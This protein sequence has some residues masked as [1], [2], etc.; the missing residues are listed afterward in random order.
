VSTLVI[1]ALGK[2]KQDDHK[3]QSSMGYIVRPYLNN[4][5][6]KTLQRALL[7]FL[8]CEDATRS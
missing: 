5:Y 3:F 8:P 1:P 2:L 7:L 4:N 6:N